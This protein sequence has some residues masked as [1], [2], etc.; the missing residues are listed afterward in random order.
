[1]SLATKTYE[2]TLLPNWH[3]SWAT[4]FA[5][6][7]HLK[8][9]TSW[10]FLRI[11]FASSMVWHNIDRFL[12][13]SSRWCIV[14]RQSDSNQRH[15]FHKGSVCFR[16]IHAARHSACIVDR[17]T[18]QRTKPR[19]YG[20]LQWNQGR[21]DRRGGLNLRPHLVYPIGGRRRPRNFVYVILRSRVV[22]YR[23]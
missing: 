19:P 4:S 23:L 12:H 21:H 5:L 1:M 6:R 8:I 18:I 2:S 7:W 14:A 15:P 22:L 10:K 17:L 3:S 20:S 11:S 16:P 13:L 9:L